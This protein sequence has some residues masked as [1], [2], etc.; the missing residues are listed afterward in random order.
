M[1]RLKEYTVIYQCLNCNYL[2]ST[3]GY[4]GPYDMDY[5]KDLVDGAAEDCPH[6]HNG[7]VSASKMTIKIES[8]KDEPY[9]QW[10]YRMRCGKCNGLWETSMVGK[11]SQMKP[12]LYKP[13]L[14]CPIC[15]NTVDNAV[16]SLR[17]TW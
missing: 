3:S 5:L 2:R 8:E 9:H 14:S 11:H 1:I 13:D 10:H 15:E 6:C 7:K 17:R 16:L 4:G 12:K